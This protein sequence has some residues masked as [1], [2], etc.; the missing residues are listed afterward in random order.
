MCRVI[1]YES[2]SSSRVESV[3][4]S[5]I[6]YFYIRYFSIFMA[7]MRRKISDVEYNL[8]NLLSS[9]IHGVMTKYDIINELNEICRHISL[10]YMPHQVG[11]YIVL[12]LTRGVW[13]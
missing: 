11:L 5:C 6:G 2:C 7:Q 8:R 1:F 12:R 4:I 10:S 3:R 13:S 9:R